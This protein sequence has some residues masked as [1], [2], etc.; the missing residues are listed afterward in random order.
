MTKAQR[1][2]LLAEVEA[3]LNAPELNQSPVYVIGLLSL[4]QKSLSEE[5]KTEAAR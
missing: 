5:G 2:E 1:A 3:K 4:L